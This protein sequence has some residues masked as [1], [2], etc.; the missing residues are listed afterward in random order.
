MLTRALQEC[1]RHNLSFASVPSIKTMTIAGAISTGSHGT[2]RHYGSI[3]T[4]VTALKIVVADGLLKECSETQNADLFRAALCSIGALGIIVEVTLKLERRFSIKQSYAWVSFDGNFEALANEADFVK[5]Y[6]YPG[7]KS[8]LKIS[9]NKIPVSATEK[10][11]AENVWWKPIE[12]FVFAIVYMLLPAHWA[13]YLWSSFMQLFYSAEPVVDELASPILEIPQ[14]TSEWAVPIRNA[15]SFWRKLHSLLDK[16]PQLPAHFIE[17]R[18]TKGDT[19][20]LISP[21]SGDE[22]FVYFGFVTMKPFGQLP[23]LRTELQAEFDRLCVEAE[24]RSHWAKS[25]QMR[26]S[27]F[28]KIHGERWD[29][30]QKVRLEIA[31]PKG[32]F[33]NDELRKIL[34]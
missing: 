34:T 24:G 23:A 30:F 22:L 17:A 32:K 8:F 1:T 28:S 26:S 18:F 9:G 10:S 13:N 31:D 14:W 16:N 15:S 7:N 4:R 20:T 25:H 5:L 12:T 6:G 33:L 29:L 19:R 27:D 11:M 21:T 3:A 2:G